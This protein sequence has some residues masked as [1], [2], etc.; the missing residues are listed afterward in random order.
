MSST[1][2]D[3]D[4]L[5]LASRDWKLQTY[6]KLITA[7]ALFIGAIEVSSIRLVPSAVA[8]VTAALGMVMFKVIRVHEAYEGIDWPLIILLGAMIP[9]LRGL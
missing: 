2:A 5:P 4:I 7:I 1:I 6:R 9:D 3:L 8:F